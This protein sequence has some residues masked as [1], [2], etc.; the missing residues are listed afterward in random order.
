MVERGGASGSVAENVIP[1]VAAAPPYNPQKCPWTTQC[2]NSSSEDMVF[3]LQ[4]HLPDMLERRRSAQG[5]TKY[6]RIMGKGTMY[7]GKSVLLLLILL[8]MFF[9]LLS[10]AHACITE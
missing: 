7:V 8:M 1:Q 2:I 6:L 10:Y 5:T 9:L 4:S 3:S